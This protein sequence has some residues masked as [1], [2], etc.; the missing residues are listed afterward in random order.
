MYPTLTQHQHY[1]RSETPPEDVELAEA[2]AGVYNC[3]SEQAGYR[4]NEIGCV[5]N[6]FEVLANPERLANFLDG[7]H[8]M[9]RMVAD[10]LPSVEET[11]FQYTEDLTSNAR[12]MLETAQ[13]ALRLEAAHEERHKENRA[14]RAEQNKANYA[15]ELEKLNEEKGAAA[16]LEAQEQHLEEELAELEAYLEHS[17]LTKI[18]EY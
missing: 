16:A 2:V 5:M 14:V 17:A 11:L 9:A 13:G 4:H 15:V 8:A 12:T 10:L 1:T 6:D 7:H 3:V 18:H